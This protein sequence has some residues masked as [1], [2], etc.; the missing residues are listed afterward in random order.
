M[1][2]AAPVLGALAQTAVLV[3][4]LVAVRPQPYVYLATPAVAGIVGGLL[5][6]RF[7]KE[8]VDAGTAGLIG[9]LL[10]LVVALVAVWTNTASL[11]LDLQIDLAFLTLMFG[12]FAVIVLLPIA[13]AVSVVVGRIAVVATDE[14][15]RA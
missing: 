11:P 15:T 6:D 3:V 7:Q 1:K 8:F 13:V 2:R 9:A 14:L 4:L 10:S 12:L 5:S